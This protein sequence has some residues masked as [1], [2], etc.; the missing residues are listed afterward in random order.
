MMKSTAPEKNRKRPD[1]EPIHASD[2][3]QKAVAGD[4]EAFNRLV[5]TFSDDL[6]RMIY[7]RTQS[8]ADAEDITQDV[9][10]QAYNNLGNLR[11][12]DRFKSWLYRIAINRVYDHLRKR[13]LMTIFS[14]FRDDDTD[15]PRESISRLNSGEGMERLMQ[16][17]FWK[18][19]RLA[20][21][22][23]SPLEKEVFLLRFLDHL[24]LK[25]ITRVL[26]KSES[27]IK[28]SLYRAIKKVRQ[29]T[30]LLELL[31]NES[32]ENPS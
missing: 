4:R 14:V 25:E 17:D 3:I 13:K 15:Y 22:K 31:R 6:F 9:F 12:P 1:R 26:K 11:N 7:Y 27:T 5:R 23:L 28:T 21:K 19:F 8:A 18:Q 2:Y 10:M 29:Q 32:H 24:S 30:T 16:R 20:L